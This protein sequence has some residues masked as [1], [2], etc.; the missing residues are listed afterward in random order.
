MSRTI[1]KFVLF[2]QNWKG[3]TVIRVGPSRTEYRIITDLPVTGGMFHILLMDDPKTQDEVSSLL[4]PCSD[5]NGM[6][7]GEPGEDTEYLKPSEGSFWNDTKDTDSWLKRIDSGKVVLEPESLK[8]NKIK[9]IFM[10]N[11][12]N[13]IFELTKKTTGE[14]HEL[15]VF[16]AVLRPKQK[17]G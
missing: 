3:Q 12:L 6:E 15:W 10:G 2:E 8:T 16:K 17:K 13:G 14:P 1:A 9:L 5:E 11:K 4:I 7:R